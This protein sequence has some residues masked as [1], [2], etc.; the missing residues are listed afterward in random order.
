MLKV[1]EFAHLGHVSGRMLRHYDALGVL[2]PQYTDELTGYRYYALD[3]LP[4][5]NRILALKDL[6]FRLEQIS[7]LIDQELSV[8][9]LRAMFMLKQ[10]EVQN[11]VASEQARL[12][13][14]EAH[15]RLLER[16]DEPLAA[17]VVL[18]PV[19]ALS[20]AC[21]RGEIDDETDAGIV[22]EELFTELLLAIRQTDKH[23][24]HQRILLWRSVSDMLEWSRLPVEVANPI[25]TPISTSDRL[26]MYELPSVPLMAT[27]LHH[28][29]YQDMSQTTQALF[30]WIEANGY[31]VCGE[32]REIFLQGGTEMNNPSYLTEIQLPVENH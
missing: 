27:T 24:S 21:L 31:R 9:Q 4:R 17:E 7:D 13:R 3:Q 18:T 16:A 14:I 32:G 19:P 11:L 29:N 8:E 12:A 26:S 20:V 10:A 28:G 25:L 5:L 15:L 23:P 2:Q 6:G 1:S 30:R 22:V